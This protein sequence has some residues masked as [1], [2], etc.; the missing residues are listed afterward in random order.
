MEF[1][2]NGHQN[3]FIVPMCLVFAIAFFCHIEG[4]QLPT[5]SV[6]YSMPFRFCSQLADKKASG[7]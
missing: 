2:K 3:N 4:V 1:I 6:I 7:I 5:Y